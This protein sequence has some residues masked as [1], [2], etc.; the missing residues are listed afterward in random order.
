MA[1]NLKKNPDDD[2]GDHG[3]EVCDAYGVCDDRGR[4]NLL[5]PIIMMYYSKGKPW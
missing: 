4:F 3:D 5:I 2:H 1:Q